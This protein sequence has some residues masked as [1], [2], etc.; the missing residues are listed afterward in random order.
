MEEAGLKKKFPL[1]APAPP[2]MFPGRVPSIGRTR[3]Q[4]NSHKGGIREQHNSYKWKNVE[5]K[6][7]PVTT[8][9]TPHSGDQVL[10]LHHVQTPVLSRKGRRLGARYNSDD[11]RKAV[12]Y[13]ET[14]TP[15][16]PRSLFRL[17]IDLH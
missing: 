4:H 8:K 13:K 17:P 6:R 16:K 15:G 5:T 10:K 1:R 3:E 11:R 9:R 7:R 2:N 14:W 12:I